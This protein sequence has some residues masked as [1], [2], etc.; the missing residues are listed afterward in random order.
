[1]LSAGPRR[2][3]RVVVLPVVGLLA[4]FSQ[5]L[6]IIGG[7]T[8]YA[9]DFTEAAGLLAGNGVLVAGVKVGQVTGV[10]LAGNHVRVTFRGKGG[11]IGDRSTAVI[12]IRTLLGEKF[13]GSMN[14]S[15]AGSSPISVA[16]AGD[17]LQ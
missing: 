3:A 11:W 10:D 15:A 4:Y 8:Q 6:P 7:G 5:D 2:R 13:I 1:M 14:G 9:A 12:K 16:R 17:H